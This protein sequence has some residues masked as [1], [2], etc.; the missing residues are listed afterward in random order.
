MKS[1]SRAH[2]D[3]EQTIIFKIFFVLDGGFG[4]GA[5]GTGVGGSGGGTGCSQTTFGQVGLGGI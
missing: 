1:I 4:V 2:R 5:G 3:T